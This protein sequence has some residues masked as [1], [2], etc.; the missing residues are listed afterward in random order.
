LNEKLE[1][2]RNESA[3]EKMNI[4]KS[5]LKRSISKNVM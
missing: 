1:L 3:S 2:N 4:Y 5:P